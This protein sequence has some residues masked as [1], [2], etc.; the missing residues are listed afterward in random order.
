MIPTMLMI[1][2][3]IGLTPRWSPRYLVVV[4]VLS[5]LVSLAWGLVVG[6]LA[7]GTAFAAANTLIGVTLGRLLQLVVPPP[8]RHRVG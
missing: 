1:G 6:E 8:A 2:L 7:V 5:L 3:I 4:A